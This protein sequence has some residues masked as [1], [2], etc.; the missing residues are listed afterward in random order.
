MT[1]KL[2]PKYKNALSD[3][4]NANT[5]LGYASFATITGDETLVAARTADQSGDAFGAQTNPIAANNNQAKR[6][7]P[8]HITT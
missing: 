5:H 2:C 3:A 7:G 6:S 1:G 4:Q 8:H